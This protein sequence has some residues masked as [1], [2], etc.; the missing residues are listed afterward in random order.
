MQTHLPHS[1]VVQSIGAVE[2]H[3]L[4]GQCLGQVLHSL[5][6]SCP[7]G[8]LGRSVEVE[9]EGTNQCAVAA[10]SQRGDDKSGQRRGREGREEGEGGGGGGGEGG[11]RGGG[12]GSGCKCRKGRRRMQFASTSK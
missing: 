12:G 9:V 10:V 7:C 11:G 8:S 6:L 2:D 1:E 4:D 3:T 5:C